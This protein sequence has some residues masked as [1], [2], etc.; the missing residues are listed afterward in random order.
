MILLSGPN[1]NGNEWK[2]VK[3]CL[4]TAWVSSIG[5]Y[6][7]GFERKLADFTGA[8]YAIAT[9]NGTTALHVS[10][11]I[12]KI[13]PGDLVIV[14]NI[15]FVATA[16]SVKHAG[17][18]PLFID[19]DPNSWQMD[20]GLLEKFLDKETRRCK[21]HFV[22]KSSNKCI[23]AIIPVHV[24]GNMVNMN[25]ILEIAK[26]YNLVVIE[27]STEAL[28][29]YF[30]KRHAGTFGNMGCFSFNGNKIITTG[31]GG[32]IITDDQKLAKRAKHITTQAK[33]PGVEYYHDE[34]GYNYRLVN[35][36]AAIG[37]AQMEQLPAFLKRKKEIKE[38]YMNTLYGVGDIS[39]QHIDENID[40]N[41]W[42]FT[43]STCK[44]E[45]L[46]S[47]MN[48]NGIQSRSLW[49]PMNELPMF[50]NNIYVTENNHSK[51][52]YEKCL[53]IPCS[54]NITDESLEIVANIIKS[55]Y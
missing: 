6:V 26:N 17:C 4:D 10:L 27:D 13:L 46:L 47:L 52:I 20:I 53:S 11:L 35:V 32:M 54:T 9:S 31:G 30:F 14:P 44:K 41:W 1:I 50:K 29:S 12:N 38:F 24:L 39:F 28:G 21:D 48:D 37:V 7:E 49:I 25:R 36:L 3:E 34:I 43:I 55:V 15:T 33:L 23:S 40:P 8:K 22:L 2:Y 5:S 42:L 16:N 51:Y 18:E 19:V 45:R